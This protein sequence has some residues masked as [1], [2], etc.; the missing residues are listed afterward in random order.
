MKK[1]KY[2][3][4][5]GKI[6]KIDGGGRWIFL[7]QFIRRKMNT[8]I[9]LKK[10]KKHVRKKSVILLLLWSLFFNGIIGAKEVFAAILDV[11][12]LTNVDISN[13]S[14]TT[15]NNRWQPHT[16]NSREVTFEIAGTGRIDV[17]LN[18]IEGQRRGVLVYPSELIGQIEANGDAELEIATLLNLG[19]VPLLASV[20]K[21]ISDLLAI[22]IDLGLVKID[23]TEFTEQVDLLYQIENLGVQSFVNS[24]DSTNEYASVDIDNALS[25]LLSSLLIDRLNNVLAAA[26]RIKVEVRIPI[27]GDLLGSVLSGAV[28]LV[29]GTLTTLLSALLAPTELLNLQAQL[30]DASVL[31]S[32]SIKMPMIVNRPKEMMEDLDARFVGTVSKEALINLN[33][34]THSDNETFIYFAPNRFEMN[35][36]LPKTLDFGTHRIQTKRPEILPARQKGEIKLI[37]T[38]NGTRNIN[39]SVTQTQIWK[40]QEKEHYLETAD[41]NMN[42]GQLTGEYGDGILIFPEDSKIILSSFNVNQAVPIVSMDEVSDSVIL[43]LPSISFE[44]HIPENTEKYTGA[45]QTS[46]VWTLSDGTTP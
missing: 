36:K 38:R 7:N 20:L 1:I 4:A 8:P 17:D 41:I 3:E 14:G 25:V 9:F 45:Y 22:E 32:T 46:L 11:E 33:L 15:L 12:V 6:Y 37:D 18:L 29:T 42:L 19:E 24:I 40:H 31:G 35:L 30:L 26:K 27:L 13:T 2:E 44:L 21:A 5:V 16:E 10:S 28:N 23:L 34:L 39:L 43:D